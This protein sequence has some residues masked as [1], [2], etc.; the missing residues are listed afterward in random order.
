M[1]NRAKKFENIVLQIVISLCRSNSATVER[2]KGHADHSA[3]VSLI[4]K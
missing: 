1:N 3:V 4:D 2:K